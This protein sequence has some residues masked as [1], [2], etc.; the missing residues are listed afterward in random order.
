[1]KKKYLVECPILKGRERKKHTFTIVVDVEEVSSVE[2]SPEKEPIS[3]EVYCP[4]H[5]ELVT[6]ALDEKT[7]LIS[8]EIARKGNK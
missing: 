3:I 4:V 7:Q 5:D 2:Q 8:N 1:M 6:V